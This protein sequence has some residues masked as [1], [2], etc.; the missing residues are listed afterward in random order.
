MKFFLSF[1]LS[2]LESSSFVIAI[3][4]GM[5]VRKKHF[6]FHNCMFALCLLFGGMRG[7]LLTF[8]VLANH[9]FVACFYFSPVALLWLTL[10]TAPP[11]PVIDII[12]EDLQNFN[13]QNT[14]TYMHQNAYV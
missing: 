4:V 8:S 14:R 7:I 13:Q 5:V 1:F 2:L 10:P 12:R 11:Q 6:H 3:K 9:G